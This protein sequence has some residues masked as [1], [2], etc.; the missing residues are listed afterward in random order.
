MTAVTALETVDE[1]LCT[2]Y[3]THRDAV[4]QAVK[5]ESWSVCKRGRRVDEKLEVFAVNQR[6]RRFQ[7]NMV[8]HCARHVILVQ[9][10]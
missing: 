6:W 8:M 10:F 4:I 3:P 7:L 1:Y 9:L 2:A 5:V